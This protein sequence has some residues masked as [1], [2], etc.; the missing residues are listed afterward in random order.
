[1]RP[2]RYC[3]YFSLVTDYALYEYLKVYLFIIWNEI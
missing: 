2:S 1:M 3:I